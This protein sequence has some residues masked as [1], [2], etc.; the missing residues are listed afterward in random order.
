MDITWTIAGLTKLTFLCWAFEIRSHP[1]AIIFG[2]LEI[3]REISLQR[4]VLESCIA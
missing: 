4:E 3:E 2:E 1:K